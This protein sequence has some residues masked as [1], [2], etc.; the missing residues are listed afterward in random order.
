MKRLAI[1]ITAAALALSACSATT[2]DLA[3]QLEPLPEDLAFDGSAVDADREANGSEAT[4][5]DAVGDP[6]VVEA[7]TDDGADSEPG[8]GAYGSNALLDQLYDTCSSGDLATCDI[9]YLS[10]PEGSEY[11]ALAIS[12]GELG[13]E[14]PGTCVAD[15]GADGD[16]GALALTYGDD[17]LLD[18]LW[19]RCADGDLASCD[20]LF[21]ASPMGSEY[22]AF[23]ATCGSIGEPAGGTCA[24][25][26]PVDEDGPQGFGDHA[27]FDALFAACAQDVYDACDD[28]WAMSPIGS[29]YEAFGS[30]CGQQIDAATGGCAAHFGADEGADLEAVEPGDDPGLDAVYDACGVSGGEAC[31]LLYE[32]SPIDSTYEGYAL[33]CGMRRFEDFSDCA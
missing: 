22:E 9:L 16:G 26:P 21:L 28:L 25:Q 14:H 5:D 18:E 8:E 6:Q 4:G 10:A 3:S 33:S 20:D 1:V 13:G 11:Q 19:T 17:P 2:Q 32:M 24:Q 27:G 12:C 31:D 7:D 30:T 15:L 23:G 29:D